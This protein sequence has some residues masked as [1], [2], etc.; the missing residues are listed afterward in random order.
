[1]PASMK[2]KRVC[3][4]VTI[5][6]T[7]KLAPKSRSARITNPITG[8]VKTT[9]SGKPVRSF[10]L[11]SVNGK[12]TSLLDNEGNT[13]YF[14]T[15]DAM[16]SCKKIFNKWCTENEKTTCPKVTV[17]IREATRGSLAKEYTYDCQRVKLSKPVVLKFGTMNYEAKCTAH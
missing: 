5:K 4:T 3:K 15:A 7:A 13:R 9:A 12:K 14:E 1:M 8:K 6:S 10:A 17:C 11:V 16:G 2:T